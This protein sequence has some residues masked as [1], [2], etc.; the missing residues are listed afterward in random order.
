MRDLKLAILSCGWLGM[1]V[2]N[3]CRAQGAIVHAGYRRPELEAALIAA[4]LV[5]FLIQCNP[6]CKG[7]HIKDFFNADVLFITLPFKRS[8]QDPYYFLQQ[9]KSIITFIK[10]SPIKHVLFSSSTGI[11]DGLSG[12]VTTK[13]KLCLDKP[14]V[15]ALRACEEALLAL[16]SYHISI[17]R[18]A[19][20]HGP[21]RELGRFLAGKTIDKAAHQAVNL[22][23]QS[24]CVAQVDTCI[25]KYQNKDPKQASIKQVF[26]LVSPHHPTRKDLYTQ[27]AQTLGLN[28]PIF[29]QRALEDFGTGRIVD[30]DNI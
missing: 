28:P 21:G 13:S 7:S 26:N 27:E 20:L 2:A 29:T 5:P 16:T 12:K 22:I 10:A 30:H 1:A 8:F 4:E 14:R 24:D 15:A 3:H 11:Y 23:H 9:I 19:G 17:L 25:R 18:F 6:S